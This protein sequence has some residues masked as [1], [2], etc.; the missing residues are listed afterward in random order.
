VTRIER[1]LRRFDRFQQDHPGL[2]VPFGVIK[3]FGDDD[4]GTLAGTIAPRMKLGR[5]LPRLLH[6]SL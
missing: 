2:G 5:Q 1:A 6:P 3:K 4:G